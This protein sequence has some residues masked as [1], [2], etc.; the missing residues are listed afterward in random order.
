[1]KYSGNKNNALNLTDQFTASFDW[2]FSL[3]IFSFVGIF[4]REKRRN[5]W[6]RFQERLRWWKT[7]RKCSLKIDALCF[8][9]E[10]ECRVLKM[11]KKAKKQELFVYPG[12]V[13]RKNRCAWH[14]L[15]LSKSVSHS[16]SL[17]V[18]NEIDIVFTIEEFNCNHLCLWLSRP[19]WR[20][21]TV[22]FF[23]LGLA[24][25]CCCGLK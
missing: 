23:M 19:H 25:C 20:C 4:T 21:H 24:C 10:D 9:Q 12:K 18:S 22:S 8:L 7:L 6:C 1:M 3:F 11:L 15:K 5:W 17:C 16:C 13:R 2:K 14:G